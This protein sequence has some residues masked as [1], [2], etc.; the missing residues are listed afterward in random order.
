MASATK[1]GMSCG[2]DGCSRLKD[3][4]LNARSTLSARAWIPAS[5]ARCCLNDLPAPG[6]GFSSRVN[7]GP[8]LVFIV[9]SSNSDANAT[10]ARL[11]ATHDATFD[12]VS[13][14]LT[15]FTNDY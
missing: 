5:A 10:V 6:A 13:H 12:M 2:S 3:Q 8:G 14:S 7:D 4:V 9:W 15:A 11:P 1:R